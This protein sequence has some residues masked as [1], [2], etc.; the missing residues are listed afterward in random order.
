MVEAQCLVE[1]NEELIQKYWVSLVLDIHLPGV[2]PKRAPTE[3]EAI[4]DS[5]CLKVH[6]SASFTCRAVAAM[7]LIHAV[8]LAVT[9][10]GLWNRY[11]TGL[12]HG[13]RVCVRTL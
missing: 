5:S 11:A 12:S 3:S 8:H 7:D 10:S 13:P 4:I 6:V 1:L 9:G 2:L